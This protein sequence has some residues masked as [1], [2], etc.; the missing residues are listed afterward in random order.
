MTSPALQALE[1]TAAAQRRLAAHVKGKKQPTIVMPPTLDLLN[2][3]QDTAKEIAIAPPNILPH[4]PEAVDEATLISAIKSPL[5][6]SNAKVKDERGRIALHRALQKRA[7]WSIIS[8]LLEAYPNGAMEKDS[9][10]LLPLHIALLSSVPEAVVVDLVAYNPLAVAI[11]EPKELKLPLHLVLEGDANDG[12]IA[13]LLTRDKSAAYQKTR[14]GFL[15]MHIA[16]KNDV[17]DFVLRALLMANSEAPLTQSNEGM[18]PLHYAAKDGAPESVVKCLLRFDASAAQVTDENHGYLPLHWAV[19]KN[20]SEQVVRRLIDAFPGGCQAG[21]DLGNLPLH[22]AVE[23]EASEETIR[24][25]ISSYVEACNQLNSFG[26]R[27]YDVALAKKV[28]AQNAQAVLAL[29][30]KHNEDEEPGFFETFIQQGNQMAA[31]AFAALF[32]TAPVPAPQNIKRSPDEVM[33]ELNRLRNLVEDG[34]ISSAEFDKR[35][36][37]IL[38]PFM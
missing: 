21:D 23:N 18:V 6:K 8:A 26:K 7:S 24:I 38:T 16:A 22:V 33:A 13:E 28:P 27:P 30:E 32:D 10:N 14:D 9:A 19:A 31:A 3:G 15:P 11:P 5:G 2:R 12:V 36:L 37:Q 35:R 1:E 4:I 20:Q 25:L 29:L 34:A 17:S